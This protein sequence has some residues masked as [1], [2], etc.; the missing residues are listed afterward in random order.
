MTII[1][2]R[3]NPTYID[4]VQER[5]STMNTGMPQRNKEAEMDNPLVVI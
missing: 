2:G 3:Y 1:N 4:D 5:S